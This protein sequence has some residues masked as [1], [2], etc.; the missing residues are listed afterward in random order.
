[1]SRT[2]KCHDFRTVPTDLCFVTVFDRLLS[3]HKWVLFW[4]T[5]VL[6]LSTP[7]LKL[8]VLLQC[9]WSA[10]AWTACFDWRDAG[11]TIMWQHYPDLARVSC[12]PLAKEVVEL[13]V[14]HYLPSKRGVRVFG[15]VCSSLHQSN[16]QEVHLREGWRQ[17]WRRIRKQC[18]TGKSKSVFVRPAVEKRRSNCFYCHTPDS[19]A[20]QIIRVWEDNSVV[21]RK[22]SRVA[23][24]QWH[25]INRWWHATVPSR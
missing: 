23:E 17:N 16:S 13:K 11:F 24:A 6:W 10:A 4:C 20:V 12:T 1:M 5:R 2:L 25:G 14:R 15:G 19:D 7:A 8:E 18:F 21:D 9:K 22:G 3:F